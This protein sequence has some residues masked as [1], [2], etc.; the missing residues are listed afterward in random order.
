VEEFE[1]MRARANEI[2]NELW[3][4]AEDLAREAPESDVL[5]LY[6]D[7]LNETID[8]NSSRVTVGLYARVPESVLILLFVGAAL[9]LGVMGFNSGLTGRRSP[10]TAIVMICVLGAVLTLIIDIDHGQ[11]GTVKVGQQPIIDLAEQLGPPSE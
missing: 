11:A 1:P 3:V 5:A 2:N 4:I 9:A 7:S 6:I 8:M 10:L